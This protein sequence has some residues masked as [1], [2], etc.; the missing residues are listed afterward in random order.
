MFTDEDLHRFLIMIKCKDTFNVCSKFHSVRRSVLIIGAE[1][2]KIFRT[3]LPE[4]I[5]KRI[6]SEH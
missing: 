4:D 5:A 3:E 1:N 2:D 6:R